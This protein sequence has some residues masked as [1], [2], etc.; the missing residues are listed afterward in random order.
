MHRDRVAKKDGRV[1]RTLDVEELERIY[2]S[3]DYDFTLHSGC[4]IG[5]TGRLD[6]GTLKPRKQQAPQSPSFEIRWDEADTAIDIE[7]VDCTNSERKLFKKEVAGYSGHHTVAVNGTGRVAEWKL[8]WKGE[9]LYHGKIRCPVMREV[10]VKLGVRFSLTAEATHRR[11]CCVCGEYFV[12]MESSD[13][14][15]PNCRAFESSSRD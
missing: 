7:V 15:C 5:A 2:V 3:S 4:E 12:V 14:L 1:R 8:V 6:I 9:C 10:A 11:P 13:R